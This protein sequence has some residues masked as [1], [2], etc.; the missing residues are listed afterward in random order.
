[1]MQS[2]NTLQ[3]QLQVWRSTVVWSQS[4]SRY[5]SVISQQRLVLDTCYDYLLYQY[6][7]TVFC[8]KPKKRRKNEKTITGRGC[9]MN[10][11]RLCS[12]KQTRKE[13]TMKETQRFF[14]ISIMI[15]L[16]RSVIHH[17]CAVMFTGPLLSATTTLYV[18]IIATMQ[19]MLDRQEKEDQ[20]KRARRVANGMKYQHDLDEQL[21]TLRNKSKM[22]LSSK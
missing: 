8:R 10:S 4:V 17:C 14:H 15:G 7:R 6:Q 19:Q 1:M 18:Q 21:A 13:K 12:L 22:E 5:I 9:S 20:E 16:F 2:A 3:K 11:R